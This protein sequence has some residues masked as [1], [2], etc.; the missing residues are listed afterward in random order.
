[1]ISA[2][3]IGIAVGFVMAIPPGPISI[4]V[5]RHGIQGKRERGGKVALGASLIDVAY[6]FIAAA[7]SS[8]I[9]GEARHLVQV[10][11]WFELSF[12]I[13]CVIVLVV[14]GVRYFRTSP[15]D[16]QHS[17]DD[18]EVKEHRAE[19]FGASTGFMLG[20]LMAVMNLA[21]PSF[22]PS[23]IAVAGFLRAEH[24][25]DAGMTESIGYAAGFG[26]GV[27]FWFMLLLRLVMH[28]RTRM[29]ATFFLSIFKFAGWTFFL[30]ALILLVRILVGT[31][32]GELMK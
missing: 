24:W 17:S 13:I 2:V 21:N 6:A 11:G 1:M 30:F 10:N 20:I 23:L 12:Q 5:I 3:L 7:A 14:M 15:E 27:F 8:A 25:I 26:A 16:V 32:W 31:D 22:R 18:E 28:L 9:I 29:S 19:K 4:A